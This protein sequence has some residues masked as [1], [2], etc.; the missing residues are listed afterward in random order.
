VFTKDRSRLGTKRAALLT[1]VGMHLRIKLRQDG[2]A[3]FIQYE[4]FETELAQRVL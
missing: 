3:K 1:E 4:D 2:N